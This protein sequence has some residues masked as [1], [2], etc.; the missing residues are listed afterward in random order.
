M[1]NLKNLLKW[2]LAFIKEKTKQKKVKLN[3]QVV[4]QKKIFRTI[5]NG[6]S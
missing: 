3:E 6:I 1:Q 2:F 5:L 4:E